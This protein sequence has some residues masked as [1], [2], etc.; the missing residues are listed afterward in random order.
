MLEDTSAAE[1]LLRDSSV[2]YTIIDASR[3]SNGPATENAAI[4]PDSAPLQLGNSISRADV[5]GWLL[6]EA[7]NGGHRRRG[8]AIAG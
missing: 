7:A 2:D 6:K 4:V 5:A 1:Q 8:L 3:L